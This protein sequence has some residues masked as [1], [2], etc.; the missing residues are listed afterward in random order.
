MVKRTISEPGVIVYSLFAFRPLAMASSA[1]EAARDISSYDEL[2][3]EPISATST[4]SGH[5]FALA[6]SAILLIGVAKSGV[7]G[8]FTY[9]SSSSRFISI[10]WS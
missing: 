3:Q 4:A 9:G 1:I 8:P 10:T 6:T 2:V 5:P 7:N